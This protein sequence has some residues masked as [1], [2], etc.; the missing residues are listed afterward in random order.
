MRDC[1]LTWRTPRT[2]CFFQFLSKFLSNIFF[3]A[4]LSLPLPDGLIV[5]YSLK[6]AAQAPLCERVI[7]REILAKVQHTE[8]LPVTNWLLVKQHFYVSTTISGKVSPKNLFSLGGNAF[9]D[10]PPNTTRL[11]DWSITPINEGEL[12]LKVFKLTN[13]AH[14]NFQKF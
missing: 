2:Q 8:Q 13:L 5:T 9:I 14:F 6:G 12:H 1:I 11:Y 10:V 7:A 4:V 3:Q